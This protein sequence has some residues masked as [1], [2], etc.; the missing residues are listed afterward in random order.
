M[1]RGIIDKFVGFFPLRTMI[2]IIDHVMV[3]VMGLW[4]SLRLKAL[5]RRAKGSNFC[6]WTTEIKYPD[7]IQFGQNVAIGPNCTLGAMSPIRIGDYVRISKG[8]IIET[9]GLD[10]STG[11][12]YKHKA[13]PIVIEDGAWIGSNAIIL[14]GVTI[15]ENAIVGAGAVITKDVPSNTIVV[16]APT[17]QLYR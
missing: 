9:A 13:K 16:G 8:A 6:H 4:S 17:R 5:V 3:S 7:N 11:R 2:L 12:P 15:G 14:G 10:L 1:S